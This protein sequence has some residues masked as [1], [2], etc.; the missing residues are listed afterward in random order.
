M[1]EPSIV[2][3][4]TQSISTQSLIAEKNLPEIPSASYSDLL[5]LAPVS[6]PGESHGQRSLAGYSPWG[7]KSRTRLN[8]QTATT[9]ELGSGWRSRELNREHQGYSCSVRQLLCLV[10][11]RSHGRHVQAGPQ[12]T[13][14]LI[15]F[16]RCLSPRMLMH[17]DSCCR[18]FVHFPPPR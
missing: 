17:P 13:R 9:I 2:V 4:H 10:S 11:V 7:L 15:L 8:D 3:C 14:A 6:L 16:F 12:W 5:L 18:P 1:P